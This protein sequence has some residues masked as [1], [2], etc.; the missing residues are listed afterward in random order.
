[1][2]QVRLDTTKNQPVDFQHIAESHLDSLVRQGAQQM[3][4]IALEHEVEA[5][6]Q[7]YSNVVDEKGH[8][9]VV[10]NGHHSERGILSG[11][12]VMRVSQPRVHDK[13]EGQQFKS[14]IL[15]AYMRKSPTI[16]KLIPCLYLKGISTS[17]FETALE[18]ILGTNCPGLSSSSISD[19]MKQWQG[20][21]EDWNHRSLIGKKYAYMWADGIHLKVR[22]G[23]QPK[24]SLLVIIGATEHGEKELVGIY[25]GYRE[26]TESWA[27]LLRDLKE[28]GLTEGPKLA[29]GD[30]ALGFWAALDDV[31]PKAKQQRCWVHKTANI[32]D[33]MPKCVQERAKNAIHNIY[34]SDTK[35]NA[36]M[37]YQQFIELFGDKYEKAV[38]C[39]VKSKE[40]LFTFYDFPAKHWRHIRT[41]NI[42]ESAF[43]TVR[44]RTR[45][46]KGG[47][48]RK[49]TEA[50]AW[51]LCMEAQKHWK[52]LNGATQAI[53]LFQGI[54]FKDGEELTGENIHVG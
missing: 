21:Y 30:G 10:R 19:M 22:L 36:E 47:G 3:L 2:K 34:L 12:G 7:Q 17:Q 49:A 46:T 39:L 9:L 8:Q 32:L 35:E 20:E 50:M 25:S 45:Q 43:S 6:I 13:R 26:S 14:S 11:A 41:T 37:A 5:Y 18:A 1:M 29:I 38:A 31:F 48:S 54:V 44:H 52:K 4:A 28:R 15:P 33:K 40:Q 51:K 24:V 53:K 23:N 16:E 42:I 27:G